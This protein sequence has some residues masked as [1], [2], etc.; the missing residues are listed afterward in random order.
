MAGFGIDDYSTSCLQGMLNSHI[1]STDSD[2]E[3]SPT[4]YY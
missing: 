1:N 3:Y 4:K 2:E